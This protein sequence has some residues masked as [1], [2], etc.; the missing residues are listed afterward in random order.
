MAELKTKENNANPITFLSKVTNEKRR[1]DSL[2]VLKLMQEIT[3]EQPRMWGSSIIGFGN[4]HY[5]YSSGREGDWFLTGFSPR[6][7][8]LSIY[9]ISG[10]KKFEA[11]LEQ[12]GKHKTSVSCL[13][14][15][16]LEDIDTSVLH[17]LISKSIN[18]I[19]ERGYGC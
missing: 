1:A 12:L 4:I 6:K 3:G 8:S 9:L 18:D 2:K 19:K 10:F 14:I 11:E 15:N 17:E 13:Y 16:K 5:K 7:Q